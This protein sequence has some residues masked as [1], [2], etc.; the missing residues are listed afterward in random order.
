MKKILSC[1]LLAGATLCINAQEIINSTTTSFSG[2]VVHVY[3]SSI[4]PVV[5]STETFNFTVSPGGNY[6]APFTTS[7]TANETNTWYIG[8]KRLVG[9]LA[10]TLPTDNVYA[11][12]YAE[13]YS[14]VFAVQL[15]FGNWI[16]NPYLQENGD[17]SSE[18]ISILS[19]SAIPPD[20]RNT[21]AN[22][23]QVG[24][25][26]ASPGMAS[27][28]F[29]SQVV[30]LHIQD[31]PLVYT[32]P[33]GDAVN[34]T[35]SYNHK[36]A[37]QPTTWT[38]FNLGERWTFNWSSYIQDD[39]TAPTA[40]VQL[41]PPGGGS[42][43]ATGFNTNTST[44]VTTPSVLATITKMSATNYQC[45]YPDGSLYI[46]SQTNGSPRRVFLTKVIDPAGNTVTLNYETI[47]NNWLRLK[48]IVDSCNQTN[49]L[50]YGNSDALKITAVT[51]PFGHS[52]QLSYLT[53]NSALRLVSI[54][55]PVSITSGF[56]YGPS[57][58]ISKLTTPY[59]ATSFQYTETNGF[60]QLTA[61]DPLGATECIQYRDTAGLSGYAGPTGMLIDSNVGLHNT[62]YWNKKAWSLA[63]NQLSQ[64][65]ITH[66]AITGTTL[67]DA[68]LF[69][70]KPLETPV[71]FNYK[72]QTAAVG[73][74]IQ[75]FLP[76]Q[77]GSILDGST[78]RTVALAYD[79]WGNVT[80][81]VDAT[82]RVTRFIF[83]TNGIDLLQ[84]AQKNAATFDTLAAFTYNAQHLPLVTVVNG[85]TNQIGYTTNALVQYVTNGLGQVTT[86]NYDNHWFLT[87]ITGHTPN[88]TFGFGYDSAGRLATITDS[89]GYAITNGYDALNRITNTFFPDGTIVSTWFNAL[90]VA[91]VQDRDNRFIYYNYDANRRLTTT[92]DKAG[93]LFH[94]EW[95]GCG[96]LDSIT[97]PKGQMTV[98]TRDIQSRPTQKQYADLNGDSLNYENST[99]RIKTILDANKNTTSIAYNKDD[100][101]QQ[102][103]YN[104][105]SIGMTYDTNYNRITKIVDP[106]T[107]NLIT[108]IP[109]GQFGAGTVQS[110]DGG[111]PNDTII[112][113]YDA[114][115]RAQTIQIGSVNAT[116]QYDTNGRIW[117]SSNLLG[118][119]TVQYD[120]ATQKPTVLTQPNGIGTVFNYTAVSDGSRLQS[121]ITTNNTGQVIERHDYTYDVRNLILTQ[122]STVGTNVTVWNYSYDVAQQLVGAI[123]YTSSTNHHYSYAYDK[124]GNRTSDQVDATTATENP[125]NLNQLTS[126]SGGGQVRVSGFINQTGYVSVAGVPARMLSASNFTTM[127]YVGVGNNYFNIA[128]TNVSGYGTAISTNIS[129]SANGLATQYTYD[130]AGNLLSKINS[131]QAYYFG[132][133]SANRCTSITN[134]A[135]RTIIEYDG[136]NR[137]THITEFTST[138]KTADRRFIWN[139]VT[140]AEERDGSGTNVI[141]RFFANGFWQT[142]TNYYY[143][144][145]QLGSIIQVADGNGNSLAT[146]SYDPYGTRTATGSLQVDFGFA[147]LFEHQSGLQFAVF[148]IKDGSRWI[149]RDPMQENGGWNLYSYCNGNPISF[150]DILGLRDYNAVATRAWLTV[151]YTSATAGPIQ[152][153]LNIRNNSKGNGIYDTGWNEHEK[154]T[155]CVNGVKLNADQFGNFL[156]GFQA[157][158]YDRTYTFRFP[159]ATDWLREH[160]IQG[161]YGADKAAS[162]V[163]MNGIPV[164]RNFIRV[165]GVLYHI[166]G[167]TKAVGDPLDFTGMP[168]INAGANYGAHF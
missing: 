148:R 102:V 17:S 109:A 141:K 132:W 162:S 5:Y 36:E 16:A 82:G 151:A 83:S 84:V 133:D 57:N 60:R 62:Y 107:T 15:Q 25:L 70:S 96:A 111:L 98:W 121:M 39:P 155:W 134:G 8:G 29:S 72:G 92:Q 161:I 61:T 4:I 106:V 20:M 46:Y 108:Y 69:T 125:N 95:C 6:V 100:T 94:S 37:L 67:V 154:D 2:S 35:F 27:Y 129:I 166:T 105:S 136:M 24:G 49:V 13:D 30:G 128:A 41:F 34:V 135:N 18:I 127:M 101:L 115:G 116:V 38:Y 144:K 42:E 23:K 164:A 11:S 160:L 113:G 58:F 120:G 165:V 19:N 50:T 146:F 124:A 78:Q 103:S 9:N 138:N 12:F 79:Q 85:S 48:S 163:T 73:T 75:T 1:L 152:G 131:S 33:V 7:L 65:N 149:N 71:W 81:A 86:F 44:Y 97:D 59:G 76:T 130:L 137:W 14:A 112:Y 26:C 90:D 28:N 145:D 64:A 40:N 63:P 53:T 140:L 89:Q 104:G 51:D 87:N 167:H 91:A 77:I 150:F 158:A 126:R 43:V 31:T 153:L 88:D 143:T 93:R 45:K 168:D 10:M 21:L 22:S 119:A 55:D 147:G 122:T 99:S 3:R 54:T 159:S 117:W 56:T 52:A 110:I 157:A 123:A 47:T 139:G 80:N 66:W 114:L 74:G 142:G 156:A 68:T 32:P 118:V